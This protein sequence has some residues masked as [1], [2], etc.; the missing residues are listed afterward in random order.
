MPATTTEARR[1][2]RTVPPD[3]AGSRR[4]VVYLA[5]SGHTGSTL[6]ALLMN[7]HPA[8]ASVGEVAVKPRIRHRNDAHRQK[9]SCGALVGDCGFWRRIFQQ[10]NEQGLEFGPDTWT[11]DYRFTHPL[12]HRVFTRESSHA[13]VRAFRGWSERRLPAYRRRIGF[14]DRVNAAFVDAVL[15]A[16]EADVFFDTSK[17]A[18][19]LARLLA[20]PEFDV[21]VV[22]LVRDVRAFAASARRRGV[23]LA[24]AAGTW[25]KDQLTIRRE[26]AALSPDRRTLL[27]YEDLCA[28]P[29]AT[30]RRL[31]DFCGV[32]HAEFP[33]RLF[34]HEHHV[35]GNNMRMAGPIEV[36]LDQRWRAELTESDQAKAVRIAGSL[37]REFGYD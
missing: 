17:G 22:T 24:E 8:V 34:S 7:T 27:R 32:A 15:E 3:D 13:L 36:R 23:S 25:K 14:I 1:P 21:R 6:L 16:T 4:R 5:G 29:A 33:R 19:R 18:V 2:P 35:L 26:V 10:V 37:H 31:C 12:L 11:N 28:D 30:L 9:C 20:S